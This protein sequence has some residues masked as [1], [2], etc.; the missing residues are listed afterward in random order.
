MRIGLIGVF[1]QSAT[2]K[3]GREER[4]GEKSTVMMTMIM[5]MMRCLPEA[6]ASVHAALINKADPQGR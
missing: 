3:L 6:R 4:R 5:M 1:D 2:G